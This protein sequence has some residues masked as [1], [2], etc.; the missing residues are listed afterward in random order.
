[1]LQ[2]KHECRHHF[3]PLFNRFNNAECP[4][5][6]TGMETRSSLHC[7]EKTGTTFRKIKVAKQQSLPKAVKGKGS[8]MPQFPFRLSLWSVKWEKTVAVF[9]VALRMKENAEMTCEY[10]IELM[11]YVDLSVKLLGILWH[12][13]FW[14]YDNTL[15]NFKM[16]RAGS[17][18]SGVALLEYNVFR[19]IRY[20]HRQRAA[21]WY[22][23][24]AIVVTSE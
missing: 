3:H 9:S 17:E 24:A 7:S 19:K 10:K 2:D 4:G 23:S 6:E 22:A 8:L 15:P 16:S 20:R 11:Q 21:N 1:M 12:G 14:N 18:H 13:L 5:T